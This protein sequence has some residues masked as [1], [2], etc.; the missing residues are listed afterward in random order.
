VWNV[1]SGD[2]KFVEVKGPGD[3]L[4]ENQKVVVCRVSTHPS[5]LTCTSIQIWIDVLLRAQAAV[6]VCRVCE[7]GKGDE[8]KTGRKRT[9]RANTNKR[10]GK[11]KNF[12]ESDTEEEMQPICESEDEADRL[13]VFTRVPNFMDDAKESMMDPS[14]PSPKKRKFVAEVVISTPTPVKRVKRESGSPGF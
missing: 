6:E 7:Q 5:H 13:P 3:N 1:D 11:A 9:S 4:Q 12:V 10:R 8:L 14:S 2:C